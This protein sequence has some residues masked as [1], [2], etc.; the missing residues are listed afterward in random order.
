MECLEKVDRDVADRFLE[1]SA[2]TRRGLVCTDHRLD[3]PWL[4][5]RQD[6]RLYETLIERY[7]SKLSELLQDDA[8][9]DRLKSLRIDFAT[10]ADSTETNIVSYALAQD[11]QS[12]VM[13][14]R[15]RLALVLHAC[16]NYDV[17]A[18]ES[19]LAALNELHY[20]RAI[21]LSRVS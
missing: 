3:R 12:P 18:V 9:R 11:A 20:E 7:L 6:A 19:R 1:H 4:T 14:L 13:A 10:T 21:V 15:G 16:Q 5:R 8:K 2:F 17:K